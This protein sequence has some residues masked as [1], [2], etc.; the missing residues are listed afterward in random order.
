MLCVEHGVHVISSTEELTFPAHRNGDLTAKLDAAARKAG[1]VIFGTGINPGFVMDA[2]PITLT[3][4]C[5]EVRS[6]R[7]ERIVDVA[8][9]RL[10]LQRKIGAGLSEAEFYDLVEQGKLG[11]IGL[12]ES[13][14]A[15][16]DALEWEVD[17]VEETV[18]PILARRDFDVAIG[19]VSAGTVAGI[20]HVVRAYHNSQERICLDLTMCLGAEEPRDAVE[21]EGTP[22]VRM[23]IPGGIFGD[24][25]TVACLV[26]AIPRVLASSPGVKTIKEMPIPRAFGGWGGGG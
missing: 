18:D 25:A 16:R 7:A 5:T 17:F 14:A 24:T 21:I 2:L 4:V 6:V 13:M 26:N 8:K 23:V 3:S 10:P 12:A 15:I 22:P 1:V 20:K 11:H 9:R 19:H